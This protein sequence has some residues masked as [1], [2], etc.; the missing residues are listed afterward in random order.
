MG[1]TKKKVYEALVEGATSG[2]TDSALYDHVVK[3]VPKAN[4]KRIVRASL[5]ALS[6]PD[7]TDR[8]ILNVIYALAI[9]HRLADSGGAEDDDESET[10]APAVIETAPAKPGRSKARPPKVVSAPSAAKKPKKS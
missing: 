1:E 3:R 10:P 5:L 6:D 8:N 4:N 7:L 9:K 2:L